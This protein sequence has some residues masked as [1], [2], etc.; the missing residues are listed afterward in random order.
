MHPILP[1]NSWESQELRWSLFLVGKARFLAFRIWSSRSIFQKRFSGRT[2]LDVE[3]FGKKKFPG[4]GPFSH[5]S[6]N[7]F[8]FSTKSQVTGEHFAF[9]SK[10]IWE[11]QQ[12]KALKIPS[13]YQGKKTANKK[14]TFRLSSQVYTERTF[15]ASDR[16]VNEW[17]HPWPKQT[18]GLETIRIF[19]TQI[20]YHTWYVLWT[21]YEEIP[22]ILKHFFF[23]FG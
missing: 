3:N 11:L 1:T 6:K 9:Q 21:V 23:R 16:T 7:S 18:L 8:R 14:A 12:I 20:S 4:P 15:A 22:D 19:N 5:K 13:L 17:R 2:R 10:L